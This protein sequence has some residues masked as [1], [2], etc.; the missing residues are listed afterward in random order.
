MP[1][2]NI[3][4]RKAT[5]REGM[6]LSLTCTTLAKKSHSG[7]VA[8]QVNAIGEALTTSKTYPSTT[9]FEATNLDHYDSYMQDFVDAWIQVAGEEMVKCV[10]FS[11]NPAKTRTGALTEKYG[12]E[13]NEIWGIPAEGLLQ[14]N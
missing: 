2:F 10:H 8:C 6:A 12:K 3:C 5:T 14:Q 4:G 1:K 13:K 9:G 7:Q 11:E